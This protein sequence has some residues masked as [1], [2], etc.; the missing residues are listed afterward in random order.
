MTGWGS[1]DL[2]WG[3]RSRIYADSM[4]S[5]LKNESVLNK[6]AKMFG[7]FACGK[8]LN[9]EALIDKLLAWLETELAHQSKCDTAMPSL[10]H[11]VVRR[12]PFARERQ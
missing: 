6:L 12:A 5:C 10:T 11:L 8:N 1:A 7:E 2:D 9:D 4:E 3:S